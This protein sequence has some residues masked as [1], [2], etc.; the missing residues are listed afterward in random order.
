[1][2]LWCQSS[3]VSVTARLERRSDSSGKCEL[4]R[5]PLRFVR[6]LCC[7][8][9][10]HGA[11]LA[12]R[13][14]SPGGALV[15]ESHSPKTRGVPLRHV[16]TSD[17]LR[18]SFGEER[19][20]PRGRRRGGLARGRHVGLSPS[21][22]EGSPLTSAPTVVC[23]RTSLA[24]PLVH[25]ARNRQRCVQRSGLTTTSCARELVARGAHR[26]EDLAQH[27]PP[28]AAILGVARVKAGDVAMI[29]R[30]RGY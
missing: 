6:L 28:W 21:S 13:L 4:R 30:C 17:P 3:Q 18:G 29:C 10:P 2:L 27:A 23:A 11:Y 25:D 8:P 12:S 22:C 26:R 5:T 20:T 7:S 19:C 24:V 1:M 14:R 15:R 16:V 9:A